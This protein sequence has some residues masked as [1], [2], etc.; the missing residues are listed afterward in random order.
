M[1]PLLPLLA[2]VTATAT[3]N[4][5]PT[6]SVTMATVMITTAVEIFPLLQLLSFLLVIGLLLYKKSNIRIK[7]NLDSIRFS[8]YLKQEYL[9]ATLFK[10]CDVCSLLFFFFI[11]Y[12]FTCYFIVFYN[13]VCLLAC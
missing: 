4:T 12:S 5:A 6:G 1:L 13:C 3:A 11:S 7:I 8:E 9:Y 10:L 2:A